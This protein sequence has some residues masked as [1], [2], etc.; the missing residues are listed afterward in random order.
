MTGEAG[1]VNNI[2]A[3]GAI[4][5][6][7]PEAGTADPATLNALGAEFSLTAGQGLSLDTTV[8]LPSG[9]LGLAAGGDLALGENA[10]VDMSGRSVTFFD[11]EERS[12]ER[13]V[14]QACVRRWR[15]GWSQS[16]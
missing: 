13:R 11:A 14:G 5:V 15:Y 1:S 7:A 12:E 10:Y 9:K 3:G 16:Q 4:R 2:T 6:A 8:A